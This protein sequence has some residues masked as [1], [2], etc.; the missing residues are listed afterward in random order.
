MKLCGKCKI[1]KEVLD[2][3]KDSNKKDGLQTMCRVCS[4]AKSA[5]HYLNNKTSYRLSKKKSVQTLREFI[6]NCLLEHPCIDCGETD[7]VCLD[8]DHVIGNKT[9]N[10]S[11]M[12]HNGVSIET[13]KVEMEKCVVRCANCHRKKTAKDFGW[14]KSKL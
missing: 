2:F 10:I 4:N 6:L 13:I 9:K 11:Q 12:I 14:F 5:A 3:N 7:P 8:F 1:E